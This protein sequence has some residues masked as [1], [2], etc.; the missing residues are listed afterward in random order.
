MIDK[1]WSMYV[2]FK[3]AEYYFADYSVVSKRYDNIISAICLITSASCISGWYVWKE[4][5][6]IWAVIIGL[7]QIISILKPLFP[8]AKR[9]SSAEYLLQDLS[10]LLRLTDTTWGFDGSCISDD[11]FRF[12]IDDYSK[13]YSEIEMRFAPQSLFPR[14]PRLHDLAQKEAQTY[15]S[16][17]FQIHTKEGDPCA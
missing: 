4:Y 15:F 14:N 5:S 1:Y 3:I 10:T 8:F 12:Y 6:L 16:S 11:D 17:R 7:S 9:V 13:H 2:D